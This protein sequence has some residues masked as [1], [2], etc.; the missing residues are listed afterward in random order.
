MQ[1]LNLINGQHD[2]RQKW[3]RNPESV[4]ALL[5]PV[6]LLII[7]NGFFKL[8]LTVRMNHDLS[9]LIPSELLHFLHA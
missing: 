2:T 4:W 9:L 6:L 8:T 3:T 5:L 7:A 1:P